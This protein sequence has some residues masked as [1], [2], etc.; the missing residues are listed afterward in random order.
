MVWKDRFGG[1]APSKKDI[2]RD[3]EE[4]LKQHLEMRTKDFEQSGLDRRSAEAK[5]RRR[6]GDV[7]KYREEMLQLKKEQ[8]RVRKRARYLEELVQD[9]RFGLRQLRRKPALPLMIVALL[10]IGIGANTAVFSAV[11]AVVLDPL[12]YAEPDRLVMVW[13]TSE[14]GSRSPASYL[15]FKD[16][17]T[18]SRSF[19]DIGIFHFWHFNLSGDSE[20]ERIKGS[21]VSAGLFEIL[22]VR[23]QL[24]RTLLPEEDRPGAG[25]V[26]LISDGLWRR[27][28]GADPALL[29]RAVVIDGRPFTVVGIMPPDFDLPSPWSSGRGNELWL[30]V[31]NPP[32]EDTILPRRDTHYF[33]SVARLATGASIESAQEEMDAI[34]SRLAEQYPD[35]NESLGTRI[36]PLHESFV[37]RASSQ[38]LVLL[39]AAGLVLLIVC[40]NVA[41]L[42]MARATTRQREVALRSALGAGRA[43]LLR[44]QFFENLPLALIGGGLGFVLALWGTEALESFIPAD[45]ARIET[46]GFDSGVFGFSLG[47]SFVT[48]ILF[49]MLPAWASAKVEIGEALK[50]S[51][52]TSSLGASRSFA[53]NL[54]L[55]G[56]F[57]TA[58]ILANAAV[59]MVE[60]FITLNNRDYG[61]DEHN[62]LTVQVSIQGSQYETQNQIVEFYDRILE[63]LQSSFG[64]RYAAAASKLPLFGGTSAG[65]DEAEGHDF[66][67][68]KGPHAE[69]SVVTPDYFQAMGIPL[70]RG[71]TFLGDD[72]SAG[73]FS[74]IINKKMVDELWPN[75]DPLGKQFSFLP[76]YQWTVVGVVGDVRQWGPE[77]DTFPEI[78]MPLAPLPTEL[79]ALVTWV[80]YVVVRADSDPLSAVGTIRQSVANV[81]PHQPISD[82]RTTAEMLDGSL[83]RRRFNTLLI[84]LFAAI[85]LILVTA[86]IYGVMSFF[87]AERK[88]EIGIRMAMGS[89]RTEVQRIILGR[90]LKL[91]SIGV[92]LGLV[93]IFATTK[94]TESMVYGVSPT[95]LSTLVGGIAF[96]VGIGLL[97]ALLP[98]LRASR[99]DP[100]LAL[101]QE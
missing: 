30:S 41:G 86:G 12:P 63:R 94:V 92:A 101:R 89:S 64:I 16:W 84:G 80:R 34:A 87:V 45:I 77:D 97:G 25:K 95:D 10:A 93:G 53:R 2:E 81:D 57:A 35:T 29:G 23:P 19:K 31:H 42:L 56:Q 44:Q 8:V 70:L 60:S 66:S 11:K 22:G 58:L 15:D 74:A 46:V 55:I 18:E 67:Q 75:Q 32:V 21:M 98:A 13:G 24:G 9:T 73:R 1:L 14:N 48:G 78:Y 99:V 100:I 38:L 17:R 33:A 68:T 62:V 59:L 49:T 72:R 47:I 96:L 50:Q 6:F 51:Q 26:V 61:F 82:I 88:H 91:T 79:E 40:G 52:R 85:A 39:G 37:G 7:E 3:I 27:R 28:Y 76:P 71:R 43:R 65:I 36:V 90:A 5:A 54:L 20:P 69:L 4:E 83:A